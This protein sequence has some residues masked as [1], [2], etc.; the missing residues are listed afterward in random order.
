MRKL[1]AEKLDQTWFIDIDGTIFKHRTND[2]LDHWIENEK[3]SHLKEEILN[4]V[5]DWFSK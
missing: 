5:Q 4:G 3:R 2:E 1:P